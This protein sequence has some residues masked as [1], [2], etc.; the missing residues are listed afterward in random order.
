M[1]G[2]IFRILGILALGNSVDIHRVPELG[3]SAQ[4]KQPA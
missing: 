3:A 2:E 4:A 1:R